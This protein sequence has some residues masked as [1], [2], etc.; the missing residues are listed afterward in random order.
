MKDYL[1]MKRIHL[2]FLLFL[3]L[4]NGFLLCQENDPWVLEFGVNVVDNSGSRFDELLNIKENWNLS[5]LVKVSIEK[6][7]EYD[8]G[9]VLGVSLNEFTVGKK[10]NSEI[11]NEKANYFAVDIMIKNY[12]SNY[13]KDPRHS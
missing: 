2:L 6:R 10:I 13:W 7:F 11:N 8:F 3:L 12:I 9:A 5:K 4:R 1:C